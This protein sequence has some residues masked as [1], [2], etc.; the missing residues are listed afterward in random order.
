MDEMTREMYGRHSIHIPLNLIVQKMD[1]DKVIGVFQTSAGLP[2]LFGSKMTHQL[3]MGDMVLRP[4]LVM[5]SNA[6]RGDGFSGLARDGFMD[7]ERW[8]QGGVL[9]DPM[10]RLKEV[11]KTS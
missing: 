7:I 8:Q 1:G 3:V 5:Q 9:L 4:H 6:F 10:G 2:L 11:M